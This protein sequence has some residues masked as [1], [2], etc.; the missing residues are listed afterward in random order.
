MARRLCEQ[1]GEVEPDPRGAV[2][3]ESWCG[4]S[5][6]I[7][8]LGRRLDVNGGLRRERRPSAERGVRLEPS[9]A[10]GLQAPGEDAIDLRCYSVAYVIASGGPCGKHGDIC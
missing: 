3:D 6:P 4:A 5:D 9:V 8:H 7:K 2:A 1:L 10:G